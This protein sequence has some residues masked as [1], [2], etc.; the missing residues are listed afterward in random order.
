MSD[1]TQY[2]KLADALITAFQA[3]VELNAIHAQRDALAVGKTVDEV[4]DA[5]KKL[6]EDNLAAA[7]LSTL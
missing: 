4:T 5:L 3:K 7:K 6:A 1:T 2:L